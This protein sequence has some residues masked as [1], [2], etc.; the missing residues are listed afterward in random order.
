VEAAAAAAAAGRPESP[1]LANNLSSNTNAPKDRD[2]IKTASI[3]FRVNNVRT[4]TE[5]IEDLMAKFNGYVKSSHLANRSENY[6]RQIVRKDSV[7]ISQQIVVENTMILRIPNEKMDSLFRAMNPLIN[8]L[9]YRSYNLDDVTY[10]LLRN[11]KD[12]TRLKKYDQRQTA[13]IDNKDS[14]L[15]E[16]TSAEE[17]LLEKQKQSDNLQV[18]NLEIS[19]QVKYCTVTLDIYQKPVI[20]REVIENFNE[21]SSRYKPNILSRIWESIVYSWNIVEEII[22][23]IFNLWGIILLILIGVYFLRMFLKSKSDPK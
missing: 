7:L 13:H 6:S 19:D 12:A 17:N 22:V 8:F 14:K 10:K 23:F 1:S 11:L 21:Y 18:E 16:T 4:A 15:K 2:F 9:D 3:K 5:K 20:I